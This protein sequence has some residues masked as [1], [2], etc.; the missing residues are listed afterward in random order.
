M[1]KL[2]GERWRCFL[3]WLAFAPVCVCLSSCRESWVVWLVFARSLSR[4][5][6][7]LSLFVPCCFWGSFFHCG[8][9][10]EDRLCFGGIPLVTYLSLRRVRSIVRMPR[11]VPGLRIVVRAVTSAHAS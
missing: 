9:R 3:P 7:C 2:S 5:W 1:A 6:S 11:Q 8:R 4:L 10:P